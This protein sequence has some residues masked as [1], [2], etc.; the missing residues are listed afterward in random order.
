VIESGSFERALAVCR[1]QSNLLGTAIN[2]HDRDQ[3]RPGKAVEIDQ[4]GFLVVE[5]EKG[6]ERLSSGEVSIRKAK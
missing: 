6:L 3:I 1:A 5:T 4:N 2:I